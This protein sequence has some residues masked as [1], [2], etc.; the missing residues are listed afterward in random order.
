MLISAHAWNTVSFVRCA[1]GMMFQFSTTKNA[2]WLS[3][4]INVK[5]VLAG[6]LLILQSILTLCA[7]FTKIGAEKRFSDL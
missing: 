1:K 5:K 7:T 3:L 2:V 6:I 4:D